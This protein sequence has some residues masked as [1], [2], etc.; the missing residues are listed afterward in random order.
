MTKIALYI[1]SISLF[2]STLI[3]CNNEHKVEP[4]EYSLHILAHR[5]T[6][7][8][9]Q[10]IDNDT[11]FE[12]TLAAVKYGFTHF[13]GVET[14][15]QMSKS[16]TIWL[17]HNDELL[18]LDTLNPM[19]IPNSTDDEILEHNKHLPSWRR[20]CT[21]EQVISYQSK[22]VDIKYISLDVKGYFKNTC[23]KGR[24]I[25]NEYMLDIAHK[26]ILLAK[27]YNT[28]NY[29]LV[30]TDYRE[31]LNT[32][33]DES[34][35]IECYLLGYSNFTDKMNYAIKKGYDGLSFNMNDS[36]L[37]AKNIEQL[38][39]NNLKIQIWTVNVSSKKPIA[40]KLGADFIQSDVVF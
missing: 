3:S 9:M 19:C 31:V 27:K 25:S 37:T 23:I 10:I 22:Q 20:L 15:I 32:I 16:G 28:E 2:I 38:H 18:C 40:L 6:G 12:N 1:F 21:L 11:I 7:R 17:F 29:T 4:K 26:I 13:D 36:S 35:N 8:Q 24:N 33:K 14:D 30:E 34:T 5:G 39:N